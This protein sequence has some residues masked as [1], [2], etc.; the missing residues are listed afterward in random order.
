M[1][2]I[3]GILI[4]EMRDILRTLDVKDIRTLQDAM[5]RCVDE[6]GKEHSRRMEQAI[7][8]TRNAVTVEKEHGTS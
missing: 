5:G 4:K 2:W 3:A 8:Q 6:I 7:Q 1:E